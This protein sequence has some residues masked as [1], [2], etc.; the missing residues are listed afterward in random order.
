[1]FKNIKQKCALI[2]LS[3]T[4]LSVFAHA[5]HDHQSNLSFLVHAIWLAPIILVAYIAIN[6]LKNKK[7]PSK[8]K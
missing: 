1:M 5:G 8:E 6:I 7:S 4:P 2:F 3:A